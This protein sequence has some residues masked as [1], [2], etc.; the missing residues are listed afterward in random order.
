MDA[1]RS[2]S[3]PYLTQDQIGTK[4]L[5]M[6]PLSHKLCGTE[7]FYHAILTAV[8]NKS[9]VDT[10]W[11]VTSVT[12]DHDI[13]TVLAAILSLEAKTYKVRELFCLN[14]KVGLLLFRCQN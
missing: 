14:E 7:L 1:Y 12:A 3:Q 13:A 10:K 4:P 11:A 8:P 6:V 5:R 2:I 9:T